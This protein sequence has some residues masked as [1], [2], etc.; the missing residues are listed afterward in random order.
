MYR[1]IDILTSIEKGQGLL[2]VFIS[3]RNPTYFIQQLVHSIFKI[4]QSIAEIILR[5]HIM[6]NGDRIKN[7]I[8]LRRAFNFN[9]DLVVIGTAFEKDPSF[10]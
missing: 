10:F 3:D 7:N 4:Q 6:A 1:H 9:P 8:Q 2:T 5:C